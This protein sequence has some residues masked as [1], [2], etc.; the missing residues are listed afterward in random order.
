MGIAAEWPRLVGLR[1][2]ASRSN[3]VESR[4][5]VCHAIKHVKWDAMVMFGSAD[6]WLRHTAQAEALVEANEPGIIVSLEKDFG[7]DQQAAVAHLLESTDWGAE[8]FP[9]YQ[10]GKGTFAERLSALRARW[11]HWKRV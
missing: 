8:T 1:R 11:A 3:E 7:F 4:H 10:G 9:Q 5:P 2:S 6:G